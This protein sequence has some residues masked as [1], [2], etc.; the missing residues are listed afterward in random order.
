VTV[1]GA[2]VVPKTGENGGT[3]TLEPAPA[4]APVIIM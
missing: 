1:D 4:P 2:T 3:L